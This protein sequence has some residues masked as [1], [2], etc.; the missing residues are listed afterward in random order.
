MP[1]S[2]DLKVFLDQFTPDILGAFWITDVPLSRSLEGFDHFNY[3]FDGLLSQYL[4]GVERELPKA[5][6]FFT[7]NF[8]QKIFLSHI[9]NSGDISGHLDE[10]MAIVKN[11][12]E[13]RAQILVLNQSGKDW[14]SE[15]K[16]RYP[17]FD[18]Q[19]L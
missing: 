12:G 15:L 11:H 8:A 4:H 19:S 3:L 7:Q 5:N 2:A 18:F 1:N 10:Q 14:L 6:I 17:Q 9:H 16:K 13:T